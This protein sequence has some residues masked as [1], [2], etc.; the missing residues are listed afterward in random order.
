MNRFGKHST[1]VLGGHMETAF[2]T[3]ASSGI[4]WATAQYLADKGYQVYGTTR[5][6]QKR[7][8]LVSQAKQKY[9]DRLQFLELDVTKTESV[10][11]GVAEVIRRAGKIDVLVCNAG[12]G[13][14]GSIEEM[15]ME[16]VQKQFD[17]NIFGYLRLLQAV[18]PHMRAKHS[19]RIVL[20]SSIAGVV[21]IPFQVHY[22]ASKYAIEAF[23]QGLRQ[24]LRGTNIKVAAVRPGDI[25]TDFNDV[26][27]KHMPANSPYAKV[28]QKC[29]ETIDKNM[30]AAPKPILVAK[31]I[32]K[33]LKK[34]N[35]A[36]YYTAADFMTSLTPIITPLMTSKMK[37]RVIRMFY[38]I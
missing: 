36:A 20:V 34:S 3:G 25:Q 6:L 11:K 16:L 24:E 19:G 29:W 18:L 14:Y 35:P 21:A 17:T 32:Y 30:K 1:S 7:A 26:T 4:G 33:V 37:E 22:S 28:C 12:F 23:T 15:P 5:S 8:D 27:V 9:G 38:N 2:I 10:Q 13:V 31:T